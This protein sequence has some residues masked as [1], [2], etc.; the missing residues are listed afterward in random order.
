MR[1]DATTRIQYSKTIMN[2][3]QQK[4]K[5]RKKQEERKKGN[6]LKARE[7]NQRRLMTRVRWKK[8][9][10]ESAIERKG[11]MREEM[12]MEAIRSVSMN[13]QRQEK[14]NQELMKN[15]KVYTFAIVPCI[16]I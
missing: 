12:E 5:K 10:K 8:N 11:R 15:R 7:Q 3:K 1:V 14:K 4:K 9:E 6:L 13:H 2:Q 16:V